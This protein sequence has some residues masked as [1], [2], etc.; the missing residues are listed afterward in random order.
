MY[1]I[2]GLNFWIIFLFLDNNFFRFV[3][4]YIGQRTYQNLKRSG[5]KIIIFGYLLDIIIIIVIFSLEFKQT[6]YIT[7]T[8]IIIISNKYPLFIF[9]CI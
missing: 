9:H 5:K 2:I 4:D 1:N 7:N 3:M 6:N 8:L